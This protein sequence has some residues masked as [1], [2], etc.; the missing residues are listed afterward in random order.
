[1]GDD[2]VGRVE[3]VCAGKGGVSSW[4]CLELRGDE[5]RSSMALTGAEAQGYFGINENNQ[6]ANQPV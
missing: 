6:A 3:R 5:I 1:M 4:E 2:G